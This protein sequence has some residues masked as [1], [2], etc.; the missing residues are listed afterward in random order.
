MPVPG[1]G[2]TLL[3]D[4]FEKQRV[5]GTPRGCGDEKRPEKGGLI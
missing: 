2:R 3:S 5:D 1:Q 4:L